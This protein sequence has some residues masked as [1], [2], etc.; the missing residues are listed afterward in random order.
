MVCSVFTHKKYRI[1]KIDEGSTIGKGLLCFEQAWCCVFVLHLWRLCKVTV[2]LSI[3]FRGW[4]FKPSPPSH[5][6]LVKTFSMNTF[7]VDNKTSHNQKKV[8][9]GKKGGVAFFSVPP[10]NK[11]KRLVPPHAKTNKQRIVRSWRCFLHP[12]RNV[13]ATRRGHESMLLRL[14]ELA[15]VFTDRGVALRPVQ[16][17]QRQTVRHEFDAAYNFDFPI[18]VPH[19]KTQKFFWVPINEHN[20]MHD[21]KKHDTTSTRGT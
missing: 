3:Y 8:R 19:K 9:V 7:M 10:T 21:T 12:G 20:A 6:L 16:L 13:R 14:G 4:I 17:L 15:R 1:P 2:E 5:S 18:F 11:T